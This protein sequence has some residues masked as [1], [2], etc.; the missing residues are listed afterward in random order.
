MSGSKIYDLF[1]SHAWKDDQD[2]HELVK[3][4][5]SSGAIEFK[6]YSVPRYDSPVDIENAAEKNKLISMLDQ[7][8]NPV[9]CVLI[10]S[11]MYGS[12]SYWIT[13]EIKIAK[14]YCKPVIAVKPKEQ[15][16]VPK[17]IQDDAVKV[18]AW[19]AGSIVD[20]IKLHAV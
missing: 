11:S 5:E 4:L 1:L 2:Y 16:K 18:V 17:A 7:Q 15:G 12:D 6:I 19:D 13:K 10:L 14:A 3:M 20:A 9:D 8:I